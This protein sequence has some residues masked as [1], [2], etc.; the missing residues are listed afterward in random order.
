[1]CDE[2]GGPTEEIRNEIKT[3]EQ[4]MNVDWWVLFHGENILHNS[5]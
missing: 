1:M 5:F 3:E 2:N 4:D